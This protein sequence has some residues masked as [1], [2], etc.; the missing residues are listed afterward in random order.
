MGVQPRYSD[1]RASEKV[2]VREEV[3]AYFS[4]PDEVQMVFPI[5]YNAERYAG[6]LLVTSKG[7][8][9]VT[10]EGD[11]WIPRTNIPVVSLD[12]LCK[13]RVVGM[14]GREGHLVSRC[15]KQKEPWGFQIRDFTKE[16]PEKPENELEEEANQILRQAGFPIQ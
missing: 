4:S 16:N 3:N 15:V 5:D 1:V 10:R 6:E 12:E 13:E 8:L 14:A 7:M 11:N 2:M 9:E